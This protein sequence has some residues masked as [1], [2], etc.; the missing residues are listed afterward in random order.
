MAHPSDGS[1]PRPEPP[2]IMKLHFIDGHDE[3][4][5][6]TPDPPPGMPEIE[7]FKGRISRAM[8]EGML[9]LTV[10]DS[11]VLVFTSALAYIE[12]T[13]RSPAPGTF[14]WIFHRL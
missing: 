1:E 2:F 13:P 3:V 6:F 4:F 9:R 5:E 7:D 8:K 14:P 12:T 11:D 10:D